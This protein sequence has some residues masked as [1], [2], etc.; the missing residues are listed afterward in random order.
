MKGLVGS[1]TSAASYATE[2]RCPQMLS[3]PP[4]WNATH[5]G[6]SI[7]EFVS[8]ISKTTSFEKSR[9]NGNFELGKFKY[10]FMISNSAFW[11]KL[12]KTKHSKLCSKHF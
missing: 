11:R 7:Q 5:Q 1:N 10:D 12:L 3:R 9:E 6:D 8:F 4:E 2:R